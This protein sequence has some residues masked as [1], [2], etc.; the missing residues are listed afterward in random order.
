MIDCLDC[1]DC[2]DRLS[3]NAFEKQGD[4]ALDN[5][6]VRPTPKKVTLNNTN[7]HNY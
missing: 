7:T 3:Q 5:N 1:L 2:L 4:T 6:C